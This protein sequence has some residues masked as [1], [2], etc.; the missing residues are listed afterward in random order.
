M[1]WL[2]IQSDG[3]HK[4]QDGLTRNDY[5]RECHALAH[6]LCQNGQEAEIWGLRHA[7][8]TVKPDFEAYDVLLCAENYEW[9]WLPD[10]R[11]IRKPLKVQWIVDLHCQS[12]EAYSPVSAGCD[13]ILHATRSLMN[14]YQR[15]HPQARHL[16]F[17]NAVDDRYFTPGGQPDKQHDLLFLGSKGGPR[18][19]ILEWMEH[20]CGMQIFFRTGQDY[21]D[22]LRE[23]RIH[24]NASVSG[25]TGEDFNYRNFETIGTGT[26]L[27]T[28]WHEC[29]EDLGFKSEVNC[30]IYRSYEEAEQAAKQTLADGSWRRIGE[31]GYDLSK[32][33]TYTRRFKDLLTAL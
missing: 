16:W 25:L 7:N 24:F 17:P 4:G 6:G 31:A 20:R 27:L 3:A 8:F 29:A 2:I 26:C 28:A 30:L 11:R 12:A 13:V 1:R 9:S 32:A 18:T 10:F 19:A 5:L 15:L 23:A 33:H 21:I 22:G 14:S